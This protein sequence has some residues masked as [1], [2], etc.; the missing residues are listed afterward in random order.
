MNSRN[1]RVNAN[2][3]RLRRAAVTSAIIVLS[4]CILLAASGANVSGNIQL[5]VPAQLPTDGNA[6]ADGI[7]RH[8]DPTTLSART[9]QSSPRSYQALE[10]NTEALS[11]LLTQAPMEFTEATKT[12]QVVLNLPMPDGAFGRF[13]IEESPA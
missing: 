13:R 12:T 11:R 3:Q 5:E 2:E 6:S 1:G 7:W 4:A 9:E 8:V 10:L